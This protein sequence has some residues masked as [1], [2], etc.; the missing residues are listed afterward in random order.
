MPLGLFL[1]S[2]SLRHASMS[3]PYAARCCLAMFST[4]PDTL[5]LRLPNMRT[6]RSRASRVPWLRNTGL[7]SSMVGTVRKVSLYSSNDARRCLP[8]TR[9]FTCGTSSVCTVSLAC[10]YTW[11]L[12]CT[13]SCISSAT[14]SG[15]CVSVLSLLPKIVRNVASIVF[16]SITFFFM[17]VFEL[18]C[19]TMM[20]FVRTLDRL[21][22]AKEVPI[23]QGVKRLGWLGQQ[24]AVLPFVL[25]Y[26]GL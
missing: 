13:C 12:S 10:S 3:S 8:L 4:S 25:L 14:V 11:V 16:G 22:T 1:K 2:Q 6:M 17:L 20:A 7:R 15:F 5:I 24:C 18:S 21:S 9:R 19:L 23:L 26:G